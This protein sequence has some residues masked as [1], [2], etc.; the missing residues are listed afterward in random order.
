MRKGKVDRIEKEKT[1]KFA[2]NE[3]HA[4]NVHSAIFAEVKVDEQLGIVRVTRVVDAIAAGRILNRKTAHSQIMGGVV[5]PDE[6]AHFMR[7]I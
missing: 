1:H 3:T 6:V 2:A 5:N 4:H 7:S